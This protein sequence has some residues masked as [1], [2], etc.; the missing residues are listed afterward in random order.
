MDSDVCIDILRKEPNALAWLASEVDELGI[1]GFAAIELVLGCRDKVELEKVR[2]FLDKFRITWPSEEHMDVA[3]T[4]YAP[5]RLAHGIGGMDALIAA[6]ATGRSQP[7]LTLNTR[8][9]RAIP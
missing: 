3:L 5:L 7:L 4:V 2:R 1:P 6:T 9:F 8:H